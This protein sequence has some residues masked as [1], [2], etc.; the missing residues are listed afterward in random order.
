MDIQNGEATGISR[1]D[2]LVYFAAVIVALLFI[3]Y[4]L[5]FKDI[6]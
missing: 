3:E 2:L 6:V 5:Q 4:W 1:K